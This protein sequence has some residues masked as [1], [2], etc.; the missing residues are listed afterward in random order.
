MISKSK[1]PNFKC[2]FC[3]NDLPSRNSKCFNIYCRGNEFNLGNLVIYRLNPR[4]GIGRIIKIIKVPASKTLDEQDTFYITKYK[5]KFPN[6]VMKI[7]HPID[8]I[9][10][11]F[12][13]NEQIITNKGIGTVNSNDFYIKNGIISYEILYSDGKI[14]QV[15]ESDI[16]KVQEPTILDIIGKK[17]IDP[18]Q[19]FL[20]KYW[21]NLFYSYYTSH[22]IKCITNS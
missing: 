22:Q 20:L 17:E 4:L 19:N 13:V 6:N 11:V 9:H 8:L 7:V 1:K 14:E 2:P 3:D 15:E 10:K 12:T 5:V 21:A 16:I 18:P